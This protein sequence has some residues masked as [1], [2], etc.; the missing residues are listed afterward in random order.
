[1]LTRL[2]K[3]EIVRLLA[4]GSMG[5]VYVGRDPIIGREVAIKVIHTAATNWARSRAFSTW[6]W[7]W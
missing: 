3:F 2:G 4:Q 5:E 1:M 7:S 6:P